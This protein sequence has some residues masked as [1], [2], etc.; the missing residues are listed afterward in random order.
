M[1]RFVIEPE[2]IPEHFSLHGILSDF[3]RIPAKTAAAWGDADEQEARIA[4]GGRI[5]FA[6]DS[7]VLGLR[8]C[9]EQGEIACAADVLSD[10]VPCGNILRSERAEKDD[11]LLYGE[12][13]LCPDGANPAGSMHQITV[14]LPTH[15]PVLRVEI[16]LEETARVQDA[17]PYLVRVP[18]VFYGGTRVQGMGTDMPSHTCAAR[19]GEALQAD[20]VNLGIRGRQSFAWGDERMAEY[21]ASLSMS[22]LVIDEDSGW[23]EPELRRIY[24]PFVEKI[25][26]AQ[27]ELPIL[28]L[29]GIYGNLPRL[30]RIRRRRVVLDTF[31]AALDAGD[32]QIDFID[33]TYLLG[34]YETESCLTPDGVHPNDRGNAR[35]ARVIVPRLEALLHHSRVMR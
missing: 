35:M 9:G 22:A 8:I 6:T 15:V 14:F 25:R 18:I 31:H 24:R 12:V 33:G 34:N 26:D 27:P 1:K 13:T 28:L 29:S 17:L 30:E 7:R 23:E 20:F 19:V 21:I 2:R 11:F 10:G 32:M 3:R 5:H 4:L 16:L